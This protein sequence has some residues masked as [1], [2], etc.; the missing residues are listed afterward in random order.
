[1]SQATCLPLMP[2]GSS[3]GGPS[4]GTIR[5]TLLPHCAINDPRPHSLPNQ[6]AWT[7]NC[8]GHGNYRAFLL[9]CIYMA[10]ACLHA[11][12]LILQM[13]AYLVSVRAAAG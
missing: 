8:V 7:N 9:M 6:P 13:N 4:A 5:P 10:A 2:A 3:A 11:L 12:V 1:M